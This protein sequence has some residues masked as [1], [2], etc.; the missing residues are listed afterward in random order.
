V[1][2]SGYYQPYVFVSGS[3]TRYDC[4]TFA[5]EFG[6]FAMDYAAAGTGAGTDVCE[7]F[8]QGMEYLSLIYGGAEEDLTRMKLADSLC[9]YV[10]QAAYAAFEQQMYRLTGGELTAENLLALYD[11]VCRDY[12]FDSAD[13]DPRDLI[14]VPHFYGNPVYIISYV[15]SNDAAMQLYELELAQP[16]GGRNVFEENLATEEGWFLAFL[17]QAGLHSPF[18]RVAQVKKLMETYLS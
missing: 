10:E 18:G 1:Y 15:V 17:D 8:S 12:G 3:G 14:T 13:W 11:R 9:I 5:H 7:I 16:G 4:L 6:H 2:L